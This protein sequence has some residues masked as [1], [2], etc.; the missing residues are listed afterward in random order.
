[1][2]VTSADLTTLHE[3]GGPKA[4]GELLT[5]AIERHGL[6]D[7]LHRLQEEDS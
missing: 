7:V 5:E 6:R 2:I 4:L 1:V 3:V